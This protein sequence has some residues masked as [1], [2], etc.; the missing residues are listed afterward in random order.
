MIL[1]NTNSETKIYDTIQT[2]PSNST[3]EAN[4]NSTTTSK[5]NHTLRISEKDQ[6]AYL[7]YIYTDIQKIYENAKAEFGSPQEVIQKLYILPLEKF[8]HPTISRFKEAFELITKKDNGS[9][10]K[11][12][13][14]GI[15]L[16]FKY[17]L[18]PIIISACKNLDELDIYLDCLDKNELY[19]FKCF[20]IIFEINPSLK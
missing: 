14:L 10:I 17:D 7:P 1:R 13:D 6:K 18:N 8:K 3:I 2:I 20:D 16:M 12:L 11:A 9:I 19:D 5:D 4:T 15:E